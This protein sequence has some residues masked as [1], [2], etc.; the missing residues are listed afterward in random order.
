MQTP[1]EQM[2]RMARTADDLAAAVRGTPEH[3]L[4]KRPDDK[5]WAAIEVLCHLRD[6][7]EA[8]ITRFRM[9]VAMDEPAFPLVEPDRWA[10][11][12]QYLRHDAREAIDAF[13]VRRRESL[14]FL[15]GL[16]PEDRARGGIHTTRG[17]MTVDDVVALMA[18]HD[19]NHLD[20]LKRA[21]AG[22]P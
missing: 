11:E 21:L 6:T 14:E 18:W 5:S 12:R 22:A 9:I 8:Y 10:S 4:T 15:R 13:R 7:E 2:A 1:A 3:L 16:T 17:R 20:Q 19:D